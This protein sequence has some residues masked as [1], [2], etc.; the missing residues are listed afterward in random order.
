MK[1]VYIAMAFTF[2]II[3]AQAFSNWRAGR[4]H[5]ASTGQ[6]DADGRIWLI[7]DREF[8]EE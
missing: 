3:G 8:I 1:Q 2:A 6:A 4:K 7:V 5:R